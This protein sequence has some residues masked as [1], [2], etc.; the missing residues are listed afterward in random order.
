[1][2]IVDKFVNAI[3]DLCR[4][5]ETW[6]RHVSNQQE[7]LSRMT[8]WSRGRFG[9]APGDLIANAFTRLHGFNVSP[10]LQRIQTG[11]FSSYRFKRLRTIKAG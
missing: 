10:G 11:Q 1:M 8:C 2:L 4:G 5:S 7:L 6:L 9:G 3:A